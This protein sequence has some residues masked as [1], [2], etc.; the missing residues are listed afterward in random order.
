MDVVAKIVFIDEQRLL[1]MKM[2]PVAEVNPFLNGIF[3]N[4]TLDNVSNEQPIK[5]TCEGK[6]RVVDFLGR[7]YSKVKE[8]N[9]LIK[10]FRDVPIQNYIYIYPYNEQFIEVYDTL[11]E[12]LPYYNKGETDETI[13]LEMKEYMEV[14]GNI[15]KYL[16]IYPYEI[17]MIVPEQKVIKGEKDKQKR[18]C[19][20]LM[21][22]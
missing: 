15:Q 1:I 21:C 17:Q 8:V 14:K 7:K 18:K 16:D 22:Y 9:R 6:N 11:K 3:F 10:F 13:A 4:L 19:I 2:S 5:M 12:S 20:Y